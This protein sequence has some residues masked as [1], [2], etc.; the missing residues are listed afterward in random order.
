MPLQSPIRHI[1]QDERPQRLGW[2]PGKYM[3][4]CGM[5]GEMFWGDKRVIQCADCAYTIPVDK[6]GNPV[7]P[8]LTEP[9]KPLPT[10][11]QELMGHLMMFTHAELDEL[12][13]RMAEIKL[14]RQGGA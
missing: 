11:A 1:K 6:Q 7:V 3:G 2:A 13:Q 4:H 8:P 12:E 14:Q 5:C 9:G 10:K